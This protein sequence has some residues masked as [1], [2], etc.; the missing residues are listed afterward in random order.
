MP[1]NKIR[2][3]KSNQFL[4]GLHHGYSPS[5]GGADG[6][7]R[8]HR[9]SVTVDSPMRVLVDRRGSPE[10]A[11][12]ARSQRPVGVAVLAVLWAEKRTRRGVAVERRASEG[13]GWGL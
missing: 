9:R 1:P 12:A 2:V 6:H 7:H 8:V 11:R 4:F 3:P 5:R 13:R 10:H